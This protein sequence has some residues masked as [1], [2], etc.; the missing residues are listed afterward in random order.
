M[1]HEMLA[2]QRVEGKLQI[3]GCKNPDPEI[4]EDLFCGEKK[5]SLEVPDWVVKDWGSRPQYSGDYRQFVESVTEEFGPLL[6]EDDIKKLVQAEQTEPGAKRRK[7]GEGEAAVVAKSTADMS[8][9]VEIASMPFNVSNAKVT[10]GELLCH[11]KVGNGIWL[12]NQSQG[13][14]TLP[15][16]F[17]LAGFGK[18]KYES[19]KPEDTVDEN[20]VLP[21]DCCPPTS[22]CLFS[23]KLQTVLEVLKAKRA[24][25]PDAKIAYRDISEAAT[26]DD[27][28]AVKI[29]MTAK[30][31]YAPSP[32]REGAADED[33]EANK[34]ASMQA[35]AGC[36]LPIT[37]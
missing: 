10:G 25:M 18:G 14:V 12:I 33:A 37:A 21:F 3:P 22:Q 5:M 16:G 9:A 35:R 30:V 20:K 28:G 13:L 2:T 4:P 17:L 31:V 26:S 11:V 34:K 6:S 8:T 27:P 23:N 1:K 24:K 15:V 29:M 7:T 19:K 32:H 36:L